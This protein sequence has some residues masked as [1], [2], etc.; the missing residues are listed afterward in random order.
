MTP[1]AD[2]F[3]PRRSRAPGSDFPAEL[4]VD[5]FGT[6]AAAVL[7]TAGG[8]HALH[9]APQA[10]LPTRFLHRR[11]ARLQ[12]PPGPPS[13]GV[14]VAVAH[15]D[16]GIHPERVDFLVDGLREQRR[17]FVRVPAALPLT[18]EGLMRE[19]FR[20]EGQTVD[21]SGSGA[22]VRLHDGEVGDRVRVHLALPE[23]TDPVRAG[24]A[25]V[26]ITRAGFRA[27]RLDIA[28]PRDR[29]RIVAYVTAR[30]R[31]LLRLTRLENPYR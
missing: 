27:L 30:Q 12:H 28:D 22:L 16:G 24:G 15:P 19:A 18:V 3:G 23:H 25:V 4:R 13:E 17:E 20:R 31:E 14:V 6:L 21:L 9:L 8:A 29:E 5:G 10:S 7:A 1:F 26:R 2:L 11:Q